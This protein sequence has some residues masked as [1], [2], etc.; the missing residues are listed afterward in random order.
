M[1]RIASSCKSLKDSTG[2]V[3]H[4]F[5]PHTSFAL[6]SPY[7]EYNVLRYFHRSVKIP[8]SFSPPPFSFFFYSFVLTLPRSFCFSPSTLPLLL[9]PPILSSSKNIKTKSNNI[10]LKID[11]IV[12]FEISSVTVKFNNFFTTRATALVNNIST[13]K[14]FNKIVFSRIIRTKKF[15][16]SFVLFTVSVDEVGNIL[17]NLD[18]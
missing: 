3:S 9:P 7:G 13:L 8:A 6:F 17:N 2:S 14:K 18:R 4:Q 16:R 1:T 12:S 10:G 15:F 11:R 5:A